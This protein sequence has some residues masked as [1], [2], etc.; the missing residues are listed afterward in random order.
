M[1]ELRELVTQLK[2]DNDRLR[3]E[4]VH[5]SA[6]PSTSSA[7]PIAPSVIS[8]PA[9][10]RLVFVPRD[11]KCPIFR[12][13]TGIGLGEWVEELQAC[14]RARHLS[15]SDQAF[16]YIRSSGGRGSRGD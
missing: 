2:A 1:Q 12:G 5:P 8:V 16:F 7:P 4:Q 15:R 9:T 11:R 6:V 3:S 10:E 13:R 14:M